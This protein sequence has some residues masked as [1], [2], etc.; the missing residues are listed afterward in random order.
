MNE[1]NPLRIP[2]CLRNRRQWVN[3]K[4]VTR[5]D[6][7]PTKV[8]FQPTGQ[9]AS[10]T[11]PKQWSEF[12]VTY[13]ASPKFSGVGYVFEADDPYCGIDLDGCRDPET[14]KVAE[15]ARAIIM[16]L[17]TY[18]EVSPSKTGIKLFVIGKNST[19]S[20]RK[21]NLTEP[22]VGGKSAAIE[23]YDR[24]RYFAVTG[25]KIKGPD[26]PQER[27]SQLDSLIAE[28][29][30]QATAKPQQSFYALPSVVERARKYLAK[31]P[32]SVS[33]QKGHDAAFRAACVLVLG[34]GLGEQDAVGLLWE[35][36]QTC[37]P[38]WS[39]REITHK[40]NQAFKQPGERNYLRNVAVEHW[41]TTPV[42][43]YVSAPEPIK[44]ETK[45]TTLVDATRAYVATLRD[46]TSELIEFGISDVNYAIGG[47][48][49][50]G[51]LV[52]LAARPS[53]GKSAIGLQCVH[54]WTECNRP[55]LIISEEMS[56]VALGK[57]TLQFIS[58][59]PEEH[60]KTSVEEIERHVDEYAKGRATAIIAES[61]GSTAEAIQQIEAAVEKHK[62]QVAVVDYAQ[63][64]RGK[65]KDSY[66]QITATSIAMKH[67]AG[68]H[69]LIVLLLCQ[70]SREVEKR[71]KFVPVLSDIR[72]TG[73][74]EQDADVIL[75]SVWPW[76]MDSSKPK[77]Q[78]QIYVAKNRNRAI[79]QPI[80]ECRFVPARQMLL[81]P[82]P[83][84]VK[85]HKSYQP[86]FD[87]FNN[88]REF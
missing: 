54:L 76:K 72:N 77:D 84:E 11:D 22:E 26:E 23:I 61:C 82:K 71:P 37:V 69:N 21:K 5:G 4:L 2:F 24:G 53:H 33:G 17:D 44:H 59:T 79:M 43:Q 19:E 30:P 39:E 52:I 1:I 20:G 36:N 87:D 62:I 32:P 73:Q 16:H 88:Q 27:Q 65:G 74:L 38:P 25:W 49:A 10:S 78:F 3:W 64:L 75:F 80:V 15:W 29:W 13:K 48:L 18:G 47:G 55:C 60:W 41:D 63:I 83:K 58:D 42:P 12:V 35:W 7:K 9:P 57:R 70:L 46:G 51:E 8:P 6:D 86:V 40:I 31:C 50:R 81:A 28:H 34:F 45:L 85:E 66:E 67:I 14:G 68:K 56:A